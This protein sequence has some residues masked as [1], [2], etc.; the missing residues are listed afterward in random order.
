MQLSL[1]NVLSPKDLTV[2]FLFL[3]LLKYF[4]INFYVL[5]TQPPMLPRK[6]SSVINRN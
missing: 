1:K 3:K 5:L 6:D 4:Q 2:H